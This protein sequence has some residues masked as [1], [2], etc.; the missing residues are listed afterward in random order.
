[1]SERSGAALFEAERLTKRFGGF[2]ALQNIDLTVR[3]GDIHAIIG[4]NGAGKTTLFNVITGVLQADDGRMAFAGE[5]LRESRASRRTMRG[6]ARTFQNIRLFRDMTVL[7]NIL[8]AQHARQFGSL[9][10]AT[11]SVFLGRRATEAGM[12]DAARA[13]L[14][15]VGLTGIE[16]RNAAS[17]PYGQ[18]RLLEIARALATGPQLLLLDEPA[19]G[20][21]PAETETLDEIISRIRDRGVTVLLVEH[22]MQLVMDISD[23]ITVFNFGQKIAE[24]TPAE[25]QENP[26]VITAYLGTG[27]TI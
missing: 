9:W 22:D 18:L 15:F 23:F 17:L 21:N 5:E 13:L 6:I 3:S 14:E 8:V 1:M 4:P 10:R 16:T 11:R 19:A 25:V 2:A 7:E 27:E 12:R 20:M 24:G 26:E